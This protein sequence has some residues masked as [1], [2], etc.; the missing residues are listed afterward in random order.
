MRQ[1]DEPQYDLATMTFPLIVRVEIQLVNEKDLGP[2]L[3]RQIANRPFVQEGNFMD[4]IL[5][6]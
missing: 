3:I 1:L 4:R 5:M 2:I 6:L